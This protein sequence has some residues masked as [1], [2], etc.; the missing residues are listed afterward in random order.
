MTTLILEVVHQ[1]GELTQS[2]YEH[3][4]TVHHYERVAAFLDEL[5]S[6]AREILTL[7]AHANEVGTQAGGLQE[8]LR[9]LLVDSPDPFSPN[10]D[11]RQETMRM[12]GS[13][14]HAAT[15]TLQ[16]KN[17]SGAVLRIFSG[18][19]TSISQT[20]D[21]K[22]RYRGQQRLEIRNLAR[23]YRHPGRLGAQR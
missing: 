9:A 6:L 13:L 4:S 3:G 15:W 8:E 2:L 12:T 23:R 5:D 16:V 18:S 7:L 22:D 14:N 21:G 1:H 17:G 10:G 20:W 19:G 11:G